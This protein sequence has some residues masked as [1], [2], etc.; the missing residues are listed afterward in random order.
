MKSMLKEE[1]RKSLSESNQIGYALNA[2]LF[3]MNIYEKWL[4]D[5]IRKILFQ[6]VLIP[7]YSLLPKK[8]V[9]CLYRRYLDGQRQIRPIYEDEECGV[10]AIMAIKILWMVCIFYAI[11]IISIFN[12]HILFPFLAHNLPL[13]ISLII[14]VIV[15]LSIVSAVSIIFFKN[16]ITDGN[17][18]RYFETFKKEDDEWR[19]KWKWITISFCLGSPLSLILAALG[20]RYL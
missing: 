15:F 19:H 7:I 8:Y 20:C 1:A 2:M 13:N 11:A 5:T 16:G 6:I 10:V 18:L 4:W 14:V 17:H 12:I 3:W 9:R